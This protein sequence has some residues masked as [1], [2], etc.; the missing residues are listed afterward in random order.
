MSSITRHHEITFAGQR[1]WLDADGAVYW[2]EQR[3]LLV[4]DLHLEK[5]SF[6]AQT[7]APLPRYDTRRTLQLLAELIARYAPDQVVCL[8]DSFHD[9]RAY[10]RLAAEDEAELS[11]LV[12]SVAQWHWILGNHDPALDDALSGNRHTALV[13]EGIHFLHQPVEGDMPQIVGHFHPKI[14]VK[15]AQQRVSGKSFVRDARLLILPS[16]GSFTGGLD[17]RDDAIRS[18]VADPHYYLLYRGRVWKLE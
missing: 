6:L 8:G 1:L 15:L 2:P 4:S 17:V 14:T 11:R 13:I 7:G 9:R 18:L 10:H 3:L 12:A 16:L 5:A